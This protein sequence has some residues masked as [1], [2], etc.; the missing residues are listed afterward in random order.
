MGDELILGDDG[1]MDE[2]GAVLSLFGVF[3]DLGDCRGDRAGTGN[4]EWDVASV[5]D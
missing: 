5:D 3:E 4:A 1:F 2:E